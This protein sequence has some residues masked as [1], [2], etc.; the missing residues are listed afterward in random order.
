MG[1]NLYKGV[2]LVALIHASVQFFDDQ[3]ISGLSSFATV[4]DSRTD[5]LV[6]VEGPKADRRS[7]FTDIRRFYSSLKR[8]TRSDDCLN[9][10]FVIADQQIVVVKEF[11]NGG[12]IRK[13]DV[14]KFAGSKV[15]KE[16]KQNILKVIE[17]LLAGRYFERSKQST[18]KILL[19]V[20]ASPPDDDIPVGD[21]MKSIQEERN[22]DV[23]PNGIP[24]QKFIVL[25]A[26]ITVALPVDDSRDELYRMTFKKSRTIRDPEWSSLS[27]GQDAY[28]KIFKL[29]RNPDFK[30]FSVGSLSEGTAPLD[31]NKEI[32]STDEI[33]EYAVD[34][35][36]LVDS[37][38]SIRLD[39]LTELHFVERIANRLQIKE[40]GTHAGVVV[41]SDL[42]EF[43]RT[44]INMTDY[45]DTRSF[46]EAVRKLP[47]IG[48]RTRMDYGFEK[49]INELFTP[50]GGVR[51]KSIGKLVI[52]VTD[53]KQ[54]PTSKGDI[55]YDPVKVSQKLIDDGVSIVAIGIGNDVNH[56]QLVNITRDASLVG[57]ASNVNDLISNE[58][59]KRMAKKICKTSGKLNITTTSAPAPTTCATKTPQ[60]SG[61]GNC[62]TCC[63]S[64][65]VYINIFQSSG[66]YVV[67]GMRATVDQGQISGI[68]NPG[69]GPKVNTENTDSSPKSADEIVNMIEKLLPEH[70]GLGSKLKSLLDSGNQPEYSGRLVGTPGVASR[71]RR[72]MESGS[73]ED[74]YSPERML[75]KTARF[76]GCRRFIDYLRKH[77]LVEEILSSKRQFILF[78]PTDV[79][80]ENFHTVAGTLDVDQMLRNHIVYNPQDALTLET[81]ATGSTITITP[82]HRV[83][84]A[85][86][87]KANDVNIL[88]NLVNTGRGQIMVTD[89]VLRPSTDTTLRQALRAGSDTSMFYRLFKMVSLNETMEV[90]YRVERICFESG[91]CASLHQ[92]LQ[93]NLLN[94]H[95]FTI[96]APTNREMMKMDKTQL[97]R[98]H[99]DRSFLI[100]WLK[101]H[102][103][104]GRFDAH[105][106]EEETMHEDLLVSVSKTHSVLT[107]VKGMPKKSNEM[108]LN[109]LDRVLKTKQS[110]PFNKG[111]VYVMESV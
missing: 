63:G 21:K 89:G 45:M 31:A 83:H 106:I 65:D 56:E 87:W 10:A 13:I 94:P 25:A 103:F 77:K 23:G 98:L 71:K 97:R 5:V 38:F 81:E 27:R 82:K 80:M 101:E 46:N 104:I 40:G 43:T 99:T 37:S 102:I 15:D 59:V 75:L 11:A 51:P 88:F 50:A 3:Q 107:R 24:T 16:P 22:N 35:G 12:S 93:N 79:A 64:R 49:V 9:F 61:A 2:L 92:T 18:K 100:T 14:N 74:A 91:L 48:Y 19:F 29:I 55:V 72:S 8:D 111:M 85:V 57:H 96:L 67:Q 33:C 110:I 69:V 53:G 32:V 84:K 20:M 52:L 76:I 68:P 58:F 78:C 41:F 6:V 26:G 62:S 44:E 90:D 42:K 108:V 34:V 70:P 4:C 105:E 86:S 30:V 28:K 17:Q 109:V 73:N 7:A 54:N 36:F 1:G 47:H 66:N 39:W 60:C 95:S